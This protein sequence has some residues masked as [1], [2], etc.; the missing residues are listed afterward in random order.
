MSSVVR[1]TVRLGS[2]TPVGTMQRVRPVSSRQLVVRGVT[3]KF[4][5]ESVLRGIDLTV[6][7]GSSVT[8]LG[9]S[10]CGKTTL[11]RAI[12]GLERP[13]SGTISLGGRTLSNGDTFV[14]PER[15]KIGMV[16]QDWALF[17]HL[18]VATN[19]AYGLAKDIENR[20]AVVEEPWRWLGCP[21]LGGGCRRPS[22]AVSS[23]GWP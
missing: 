17:P 19:V 14:A 21:C 3:K 5:G 6:E 22:L 12:A 2:G 23:R 15:R 16:F 11:L 13:D 9:P 1:E 10:G 8:L 7:R 18:D 20:A 4:E